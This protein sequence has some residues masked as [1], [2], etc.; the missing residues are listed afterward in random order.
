MLGRSRLR[1]VVISEGDSLRV[2]L[3][4][5]RRIY[6][7]RSYTAGRTSEVAGEGEGRERGKAVAVVMVAGEAEKRRS[8]GWKGSGE[9]HQEPGGAAHRLGGAKTLAEVYGEKPGAAD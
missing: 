3:L 2:E 9:E 5:G 8:P 4:R 7:K 1:E 6:P